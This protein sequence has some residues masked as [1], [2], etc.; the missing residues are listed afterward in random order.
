MPIYT[1]ENTK[2]GETRDEM[3]SF[4]ELETIL[5]NDKTLRHVIKPIMIGDPV[6]LGITKPP[7][8]FMKHVLGRI[9]AT[10]PGSDAIANKRWNIPKEI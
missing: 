10:N 1:I 3:I 8:D 2:T 9:K 7:A 4:S 5:E 6:N